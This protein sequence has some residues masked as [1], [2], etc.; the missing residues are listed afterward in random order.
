MKKIKLLIIVF[1]LLFVANVKADMGPPSIV[2]H[3]VIVTN[4]NG[5]I[6]YESTAS[7][8]WVK[9][10]KVIPYG[11]VLRVFDDIF[12][13]YYISVSSEKNDN[14]SCTIRYSDISAKNQNF[15]LK[16][17]KKLSSAK[18][19]VIL[20]KGGLNMRK[21]PDV[22]YGRIT[23]IPQYSVVTLTYSAG[24]YWYYAEYNGK[25]GWITGMDGYFGCEG[26][27][28]LINKDSTQYDDK[29]DLVINDT[30]GNVF[31]EI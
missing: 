11:T 23:T 8:G 5:A 2:E 14:Y 20:A 4:K 12:D 17:A 21:G 26:K 1:V 27:E 16:D 22:T 9:S 3:E 30:L 25:K 24:D 6:C 29:A 7:G 18:K 31:K 13:Q 15:N 19:G 10:E 28:V